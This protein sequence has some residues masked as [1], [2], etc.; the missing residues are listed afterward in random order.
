[1][2]RHY[3]LPRG[4]SKRFPSLQNPLWRIEAL[5][6]RMTFFLLKVLPAAWS[7]GGARCA[8]A[9]FGPLGD[10]A[11]KVRRNLQI[12]FPDYDVQSIEQLVKKTFAH[13]G[14]AMAELARAPLIR[15]SL[16]ANLDIVIENDNIKPIVEGQPVVFV[17]AHVEA[18][19]YTNLIGPWF[20]VRITSLYA[21]ES[22]PYLRS[23]FLELRDGLG[24][25]WLGRDNAMRHLVKEL[26]DGHCIGLATDIRVDK[27]ELLPLFGQPA[28]T[29]TTPARL[30]LRYGCPLITVRAYR[31]PNYRYRIALTKQIMP[32]PK[33]ADSDA[34]VRKMSIELNA[35]FERWIRETP[36][37]WACMKRRWPK[38]TATRHPPP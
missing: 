25:H 32:D 33:L 4:L 13:L 15:K 21:P 26:N 7:V 28:P 9:T 37:N 14:M 12:A 20:G 1:M 35:E 36:G 2:P 29:N 23:L 6:L 24:V 31:L 10:K 16:A 38:D 5:V 27:G 22:N 17:T 34:Q 19:Q 11:N 3:I 18:W 8:F 30:A